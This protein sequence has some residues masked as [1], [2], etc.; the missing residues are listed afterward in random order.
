MK[1]KTK[2]ILKINSVILLFLIIALLGINQ[3]CSSAKYNIRDSKMD[4]IERSPQYQDG[5]FYNEK[6]WRQ[7]SFTD[8]LV[9][10]WKFLFSGDQRKPDTLLPRKITDLSYFKNTEDSQLNV[11]WLGHSTLLINIDGY[12]I[13]TDPVFEKKLTFFGPS[14]YNGEIPVA[15][16]EITEI[17]LV[18]ISHNH[19][20]HLN[21]YSIKRLHKSTKLFIVPLAVG[22]QLEEWGVP[23]N[24]IIELDWWDTYN[25]EEK[26][27][28]VLTPTQH[29]SGRGITDR[30]ETLWGSFVV[31]GPSHKIYFGGDSGYFSGFRQIGDTYGPFDMTFL[32][33]GAYNEKWHHIHMF[34]EETAQAHLDLQGKVLHP[35]HWGTFNLALHPWNEPM[36]RLSKIADSLDI[37]TATPVVGETTLYERYIP[38]S[39]WWENSFKNNNNTLQ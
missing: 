17:D 12:K 10:G 16:N 33:C 35:I 8:G 37:I 25:F 9:T 21:E 11:T 30:D 7:P 14:R 13:I 3:A 28:V 20:D 24:K 36:Q 39:K 23:R 15:I 22:A 6:S 4:A 1:K 32:E 27:L 2:N 31:T 34:P 26:L 29:F 38:A 5:T 18:L 19:Y